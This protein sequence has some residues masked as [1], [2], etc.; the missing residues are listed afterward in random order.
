VRHDRGK[1]GACTDG[2]PLY[3]STAGV[4]PCEGDACGPESCVP[5]PGEVE[6]CE[7]EPVPGAVEQKM[8][9]ARKLLGRA[10][11]GK[12]KRLGRAASKQL[13]KAG[14]RTARAARTGDLS[15]ECATALGAALESAEDCAACTATTE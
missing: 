9:R 6:G 11:G 8:D 13:A 12:G 2:G 14:K 5:D 3:D 4:P 1:K 15:D 10:G 7:G